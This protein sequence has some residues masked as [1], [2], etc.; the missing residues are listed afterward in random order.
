MDNAFNLTEKELIFIYSCFPKY[1][2]KHWNNDQ[3][4]QSISEKFGWMPWMVPMQV[5]S[6]A[7][8]NFSSLI[9]CKRDVVKMHFCR[10][11]KCLTLTPS[12]N[13]FN[14]L[15][16]STYFKSHLYVVSFE[17]TNNIWMALFQRFFFSLINAVLSSMDQSYEAMIGGLTAET[18]P[19]G[20]GVNTAMLWWHSA[21]E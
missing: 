10:V 17:M 21:G 19:T 15:A 20:Q 7:I 13:V 3:N 8:E 2:R 9:C 14:C 12:S 18:T 6:F 11:I 4:L 16:W 5:W 1:I